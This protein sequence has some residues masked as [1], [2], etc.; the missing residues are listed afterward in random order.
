MQATSTTQ[1]CR[2]D[3][4]PKRAG[5]IY[6]PNVQATSTTQTCR[7]DP[8]PKCAGKIYYPNVPG[9]RSSEAHRALMV[10]NA[11][12]SVRR[13][14]VSSR[15]AGAVLT[16]L[17]GDLASVRNGFLGAAASALLLGAVV[18]VEVARFLPPELLGGAPS[19]P[20]DAAV[21]AGAR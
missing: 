4:L 14:A 18:G 2:Q 17:L 5:K 13:F 10:V 11:T 3:L 19:P 7:Q 12:D 16:H 15:D 6:Y 21:E 20:P 9:V 1:T 8:R